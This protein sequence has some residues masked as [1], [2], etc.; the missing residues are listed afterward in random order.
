[1]PLLLESSPPVLSVGKR[2]MEEGYSFH[3]PSGHNPY[4]ISPDGK[5]HD[6]EVD[7]VVPYLLDP[8]FDGISC[9]A[10]AFPVGVAPSAVEGPVEGSG[11]PDEGGSFP[12]RTSRWLEERTG[13]IP[14]K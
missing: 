1:M 6:L 10:P 13:P 12:V 5:R 4:L 9:P 7:N 8:P 3:W 2:C 14:V 11:L